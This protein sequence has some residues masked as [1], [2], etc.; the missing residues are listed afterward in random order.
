[1][2]K[3]KLLFKKLKLLWKEDKVIPKCLD[4]QYAKFGFYINEYD[5]TM[6]LADPEGTCIY[7]KNI[8]SKIPIYN[9]KG[10]RFDKRKFINWFYDKCGKEGRWFKPKKFSIINGGKTNGSNKCY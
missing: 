3:L 1:M 8:V 6:S 7:I 2:E 4:C 9:C 5:R 10:Q